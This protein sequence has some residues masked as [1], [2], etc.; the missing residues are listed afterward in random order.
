MHVVVAG[1]GAVGCYI[2]GLLARGG[3]DVTLVGRARHVEAIQAR[4]LSIETGGDTI[5]VPVR[6]S[7]EL[8]AGDR[9]LACVKTVDSDSLAAALPAGSRVL[10]LQNGVDGAARFRAAG[11]MADACVVYVGAYMGGDGHVVHTGRGDL[12]LS[13]A[14][15]GALFTSFGVPCRLVE[16]VDVELWR[17]LVLNCAYNAISALTGARY[18]RIAAEA[19]A[20]V[21][22]A[23]EETVAVAAA[24]GIRLEGDQVQFALDLAI[25]MKDTISSTAQDLAFGRRTEI[26]SLNG[27]V[28]ARGRELGVPTPVNAMLRQLVKLRE[29]ATA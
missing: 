12:A 4:W 26:D 29:R 22:A 6:A 20:V 25:P 13:S 18:G 7:T 21:R 3:C 2:G 28:A 23:V 17:K 11:H 14:D 15:W 10:T 8:V 19:S 24:Q 5:S 9:Y 1:A 27:Y 16:D